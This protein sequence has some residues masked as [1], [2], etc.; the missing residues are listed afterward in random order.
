MYVVL[1]VFDVICAGFIRARAAAGGCGFQR[2]VR[3]RS[4]GKG[5]VVSFMA[6]GE[7]WHSS[8]AAAHAGSFSSA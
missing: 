4:C 5:A 1:F 6:G 7:G 8:F 2:I 3:R